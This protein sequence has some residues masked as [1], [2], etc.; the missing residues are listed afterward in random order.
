MKRYACYC[1]TRNIYYKVWPSLNSL[2][3]HADLEKVYLLTEDNDIGFELPRNVE[4]VNVRDQQYFTPDGPNYATQWTYM[5]LMK[6][7]LCK[8]FPKLDRILSLDLD[9]IID[10]DINELWDTP[11]DDHYLAGVPEPQN[12][13]DSFVYI[14]A[15]VVLWNLCKLRDGKC[16]EII[17]SLN[18]KHWP[19]PEQNCVSHLCHGNI[20]HLPSQY[21]YSR[22]SK[23]TR[24]PKIY[25]FAAYG[26]WYEREP[27]VQK[28]KERVRE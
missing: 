24:H 3:Q 18:T 10:E 9:T 19:F 16:D 5:V 21:N 12:T 4:I 2:L 27:L 25:H 7:A 26:D 22:Y 20:Y 13:T 11:I 14:N 6:T 1:M 17:H 15:G 8:I 23:P 28:Y